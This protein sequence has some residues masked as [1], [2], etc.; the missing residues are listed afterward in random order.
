MI[1]LDD[2]ISEL[3]NDIKLLDEEIGDESSHFS[4]S[5]SSSTLFGDISVNINDNQQLVNDYNLD[6]ERINKGIASDIDGFLR[7]FNDS[8]ER[9]NNTLVN[10][11][12][13]DYQEQQQQQQQHIQNNNNNIGSPL[14]NG[15]DIDIVHAFTEW[16]LL[17]D[18]EVE[19]LY[20][21]VK[22]LK[23]NSKLYNN[24][25]NKSHEA[26]SSP[27][28]TTRDKHPE[29]YMHNSTFTNILQLKNDLIGII[30]QFEKSPKV[31]QPS[32]D[33][34]NQI[35]LQNNHDSSSL[36]IFIGGNSGGSL[37]NGGGLLSKAVSNPDMNSLIPSSLK[38]PP[39]L[40]LSPNGTNST[41]SSTSITTANVSSSTNL[42]HH[43]GH[44][45]HSHNHHLNI[46]HNSHASVSSKSAPSSPRQR[47]SISSASSPSTL[48]SPST[49]S[50][51]SPSSSPSP[52]RRSTS[53]FMQSTQSS[54]NKLSSTSPPTLQTSA[55]S[56]TTTPN[57]SNRHSNSHLS[58][59][60]TT[61]SSHPTTPTKTPTRARANSTS[62]PTPSLSL[63]SP[64]SSPVKK[65]TTP[66][67][68]PTF[69]SIVETGSTTSSSNSSS[70]PLL[71]QSAGI[72]T[73]GRCKAVDSKGV[74]L[75]V[76]RAESSPVWRSTAQPSAEWRCF[77]STSQCT[78]TRS[79]QK[80]Q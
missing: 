69:T 3:N 15:A 13:K 27:I 62:T 75:P 64:L 9:V 21:L 47:N 73:G 80:N 34:S 7:E 8:R 19:E 32:G 57:K 2:L 56:T 23:K 45:L 67:V 60:T 55:S 46:G 52:S 20:L 5:S 63:T 6:L 12:I 41:N 14:N 1:S 68:K 79:Y 65:S 26:P 11:N 66:T 61:S 71:K 49:S 22:K 72:R 10:D 29:L 31:I 37:G 33:E 25:S 50:S 36:D 44:H 43:S 54:S 48:S 17:I 74:G 30:K 24:N 40:I 77:V 39:V 70:P 35:N 58:S 28:L 53:S 4:Q 42:P 59:S 51:N 16:R 76:G 38:L 78:D 18:E